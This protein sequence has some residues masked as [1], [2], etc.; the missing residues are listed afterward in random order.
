MTGVFFAML[1]WW[2]LESGGVGILESQTGDGTTRMTH[3]WFVETDEALWVEAGTP[4]NP[5]FVDIQENPAIAL[6]T[7][8]RPD[9]YI[10][11]IVPGE[12]AHREI[13]SRLR[14]KYGF[15]DWWIG[16]IFDTSQSVAVRMI[17]PGAVPE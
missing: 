5:W 13:R 4:Q 1:T 3:V 16:V 14:E 8:D 2:A 10:A 9:E 6:T 12:S 17:P 7:F 11:E 15:R